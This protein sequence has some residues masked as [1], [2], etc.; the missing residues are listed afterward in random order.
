MIERAGGPGAAGANSP[1]KSVVVVPRPTDEPDVRP[2]AATRL[3]LRPTRIMSRQRLSLRTALLAGVACAPALAQNA[4]ATLTAATQLIVAAGPNTNTRPAGTNLAGGLH[5]GTSYVQPVSVV[6]ADATFALPSGTGTIVH[7]IQ[8]VVTGTV[9]YRQ[10]GPHATLL[11]LTSALPVTGTL[12]VQYSALFPSS[13]NATVDIGNNG[14]VE[15]TRAA[16]SGT[17]TW[18]QSITVQGSLPIRVATFLNDGNHSL[19]LTFTPDPTQLPLPNGGFENGLTGWATFGNVFAPVANPP[20]IEPRTGARLCKMFGNFTGGFNVSGAYQW[21]PASPGDTFVL[22]CQV[23]HWS[24]D[25]LIGSTASNGNRAVEKI[26]FFDAAGNE[27]GSAEETLLDGTSPTDTWIN[28]P[29][30]VATAPAGTATVQALLLFLQPGNDPG[31]A[32]F[33]DAAFDRAGPCGTFPLTSGSGGGYPVTAVYFTLDVTAANGVSMCGIDLRLVGPGGFPWTGRLRVHRALT[34]W[35]QLTAALSAP[36]NWCPLAV[37][38]GALNTSTL[39]PLTIGNATGSVDLPQGQYLLAITTDTF[40]ISGQQNS[41]LVVSDPGYNLTCDSGAMSNGLGGPL[42]G[43]TALGGTLHFAVP[44]SPVTAS[45]C[46]ATC[47]ELGTPCGGDRNMIYEEF[48]VGEWDLNAPNATPPTSLDLVITGTGT[49]ASLS[50]AP[51]TAIVPPVGPDL[52]LPQNASS[53]LLPLGFDLAAFGLPGANEISVCSNGSVCLGGFGSPAPFPVAEPL[54]GDPAA[55]V[56]ACQTGLS[57]LPGGSI[58]ADIT[59]GVEAIV[60][61]VDVRD[62]LST[63]HAVTFQIVIRPNEIRIRYDPASDFTVLDSVV[64]FYNG[65]QLATLSAASAVDLSAGP[66]PSTTPGGISDLALSCL[67]APVLATSFDVVLEQNPSLAILFAELA[68]IGTGLPLPSP[69]FAFGC[70][71]YVSPGS[72]DLGVTAGPF[73]IYSVA[74]PNNPTLLGT[75]I[76]MQGLSLGTGLLSLSNAVEATVGGF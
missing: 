43:T 19:S 48:R 4:T 54:N 7:T 3:S 62:Q 6:T 38:G 17:Q 66:T 53:L 73:T 67:S 44:A 40:F 8:E 57:T 51:G 26:A 16:T 2:P 9:L 33:D 64:G 56:L 65:V 55:R 61:F 23:R 22:A 74:I 28:R 15:W 35:S 46:G 36:E 68:A 27:I 49:G 50:P 12:A 59:P 21:F 37:L 52:N 72:V 30:V 41:G 25:P 29:P 70:R 58:H 24:G 5:L 63:V 32:Q 45:P 75:T 18:Q 11:T 76:A 69:P 14:S 42:L 71:L 39:T 60:S 31:A 1:G 13:T 34:H 20:A 10:C 47:F